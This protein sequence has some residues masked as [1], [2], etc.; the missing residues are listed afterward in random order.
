MDKDLE[1][2]IVETVEGFFNSAPM[3]MI[4]QGTRPDYYDVCPHC[5]EEIYERHEY[6]ED[7]GLTWRHSECK[8]LIERK[9]D[10]LESFA[11]WLRPSIEEY[12]AQ[13][14]DAKAKL[15][16]SEVVPGMPPSGEEK[17]N[18][19]EP[20]GTMMAVNLAETGEGGKSIMDVL[21]ELIKIAKSGDIVKR[22]AEYL[23][24]QGWTEED[25]AHQ[26]TRYLYRVNSSVV[27]AVRNAIRDIEHGNARTENDFE[28]VGADFTS[29]LKTRKKHGYP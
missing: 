2:M 4:E 28:D 19:Q 10:P 13:K 26:S 22:M 1:K 18:K 14:H 15:R 12:R 16:E 3:K 29:V 5:K 23:I 27:L 24:S 20:G 6:T 11:E 25:W 9:E 8:G 21:P 7:G 17:Y